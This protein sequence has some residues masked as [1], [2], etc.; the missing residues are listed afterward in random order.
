MIAPLEQENSRSMIFLS[1]SAL[2]P[3]SSGGRR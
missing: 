3:T 2:S 1:A